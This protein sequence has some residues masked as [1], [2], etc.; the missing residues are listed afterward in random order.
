MRSSPVTGALRA[1]AVPLSACG[2]ALALLTGYTATGAAGGP[3][4]RIEVV[5]ARIMAPTG[6]RSTAAYFE[7]RNTGSSPDTLQYADSPELGISIIRRTVRRTGTGPTEP[8]R[9]VDVPAG[10]TV[11]MAP[12]GL[13]VVI[14]DPPALKPGQT[15]RYNLWFRYSGK[16]GVRVLVTAG[17]R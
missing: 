2:A 11:R 17:P 16:V 14:L 10:G 5:D 1:A 12:G 15:V 7:I 9:A 4:P 3:P 13:A 6:A 8:A